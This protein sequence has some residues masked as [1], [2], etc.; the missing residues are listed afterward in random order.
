[1]TRA[2]ANASGES[3]DSD[4]PADS[5]AERLGIELARQMRH[6]WLAAGA[7]ERPAAEVFLNRYPHLLE[8]PQ[9]AVEVIY[10]EY[11]LRH[12][13]GDE[14]AEQDL[15]RRFPQWAGPLRVML[16]CHRQ[17][18]QS[19]A[20]EPRYPAVGEALAEFRLT[21]ELVHGARGRV[22]LATQTTLADRPVVLKIT[23]LDGAEHLSLARL[24][25]THIVPLHAVMDDAERGIRV[26]CMP[27]F[28][29]ATLASLL[30][31]VAAVP[32]DQRCGRHV[33]EAID[34]AGELPE[35]AQL[36]GGHPATEAAARQM[37]ASVSYVQAMCW[38][39]ACLADALHFAHE[40]GVVHLDLKPSNILLAGDG[41]P[42]LLDFHLARGP[43]RPGG[44]APEH[45]GGS[46]PY[47]A[48][49]QQAAMRAL[50]QGKLVDELIDGRADVYAL[51]TIIYQALGG[52]LPVR[53]NASRLAS[54]NSAVSFGLSDI[55]D[56][57]LDPRV[58]ERY[59]TAAALAE[60]LRR[61]LTDQ[62][63]V[64]VANRSLAERWHKWRRRRPGRVRAVAATIVLLTAVAVMLVTAG[65]SWRDR[66]QQAA[67]ALADGNAQLAA[68]HA[69]EALATFK[70]GLAL[71]DDLP[72]AQPL[73][74]EL[75]V[76]LLS[77]RRRDLVAQLHHLADE[78][79]VLY[80]A[81]SIA[82][83]RARTLS[84]RCEAL[85][86]QRE[87]ILAVAG[88]ADDP[89]VAADLQD[90]ALS[91]ARLRSGWPARRSLEAQHEAVRL[92][93]EIQDRF[94][95]S[96]ILAQ[97]RR[98][99]APG[100]AARAPSSAPAPGASINAARTARA[101]YALGRALL[102]SGNLPAAARELAR[103]VE[104][105][106]GGP[107]PNFYYGVCA[108]RLGRHQDAVSA[109]SVCIGAAPELA[110]CF[111]SRALAHAALGQD[112]QAISDYSR[113]LDLDPAHASS[114][115]NRGM[116]HARH[117]RHAQALADLRS[118]L[119]HGA[120]GAAV[121]YDIALVL[122]AGNDPA[123]ALAGVRR[124][125]EV[126]PGHAPSRRLEASLT[127]AAPATRAAQAARAPG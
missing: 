48:P 94:G 7:A 85:W 54:I 29:R 21:A 52:R 127:H 49:E 57:C 6:C 20:D 124:A 39:S 31:A 118:A 114:S 36:V 25:H 73:R 98:L 77:A 51:G 70:R 68:G 22:F 45:F 117:G 92:L 5:D 122:L 102:A 53:A 34:A 88:A 99:L 11:C 80:V 91:A 119:E 76:Q 105:D 79:R 42:M 2:P 15:V 37:L 43:I 95:S 3:L 115:L 55:V 67:L 60:D 109:F 84:A 26:L 64:G 44:P 40:R 13:A 107:W 86:Q 12:A 108:Y 35:E 14:Q 8:H 47:M 121:H 89:G 97:E 19:R 46:P 27:Y 110:G 33:L 106:P 100:L 120:D 75:R 101:H 50:Q 38:M 4:I 62:P 18:L 10:E 30:D 74:Q 72:F 65:W 24:Q 61:H 112:E 69:A 113:A 90:I 96:A 126:D 63:L 71:V 125:L 41:Q 1:M 23:P 28:G 116:L 16:D 32:P 103:A 58:D 93:D 56:K 78:V 87:A 82:A 17:L 66:K 111:Y 9:A 59:A 81:E 123:G 83:A 104:L